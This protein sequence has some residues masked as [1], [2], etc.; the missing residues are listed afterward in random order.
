MLDEF[1][2]KTME[3]SEAVPVTLDELRKKWGNLHK[4]KR[5]ASKKI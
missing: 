2:D 1:K 4:S 5:G 3:A